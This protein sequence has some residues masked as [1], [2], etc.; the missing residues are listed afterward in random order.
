[1]R[2]KLAEILVKHEHRPV[3]ALSVLAKI[4]DSSLSGSQYRARR[5]IEKTAKKLKAQGLYE[6]EAEDW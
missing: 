4:S 5:Q 1:M 2:L 6:L 3:Q